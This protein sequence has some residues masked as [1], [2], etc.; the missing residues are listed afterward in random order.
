M[1]RADRQDE[2]GH[3]SCGSGR[4]GRFRRPWRTPRR[5]ASPSSTTGPECRCPSTARRHASPA[6]GGT[7]DAPSR[8]LRFQ[9]PWPLSP[10]STGYGAYGVARVTVI[11]YTIVA[12]PSAEVTVTVMVFSPVERPTWWP[13]AVSASVAGL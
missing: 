9:P 12:S 6:T 4:P 8:P 10:Q 5:W 3:G 1:D 11:V 7:L 2:E 13:A